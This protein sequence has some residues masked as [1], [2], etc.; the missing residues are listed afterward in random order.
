[1]SAVGLELLGE[2]ESFETISAQWFD[3]GLLGSIEG[4]AKVEDPMLILAPIA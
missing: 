2:W 3:Q 4:P 1:M